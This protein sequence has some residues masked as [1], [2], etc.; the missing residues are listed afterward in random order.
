MP[1]LLLFYLILL[2]IEKQSRTIWIFLVIYDMYLKCIQKV[3]MN[4]G[5]LK[6]YLNTIRI[7]VFIIFYEYRIHMNTQKNVFEYRRIRIL[8]TN[9]PCLVVV[10]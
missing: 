2:V 9:T 6:K 10:Q 4:T 5:L 3:F 8:N 7:H 1:K